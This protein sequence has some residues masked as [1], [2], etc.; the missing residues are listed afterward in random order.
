M[1]TGISGLKLIKSFEGLRH[2]PYLCPASVPTVGYG[3]TV[4]PSGNKV[5]LTDKTITEAE[6]ET[7]LMSD[8]D[9][10]ERSVCHLTTV[11]LTQNRFDALVSFAY[12]VGANALATSTLLK[13]LNKNPNDPTIAFEFSRWNKAAGKVLAGLTRRRKAEADLYFKV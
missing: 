1:R 12:N 8:L 13:K 10:F 4:Y 2:K 6:A 11:P 7:Y 3:T 5:K 9:K